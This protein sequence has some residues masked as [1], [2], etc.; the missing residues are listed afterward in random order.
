MTEE[1]WNVKTWNELTT[2]ELHNVLDLR[3][4]VF[5]V[6]QECPYPELDGKDKSAL[7][8]WS[9]DELGV[10][11]YLRILP[12]G[13]SYKE[14]SIGRVVVRKGV[15]KRGLGRLVMHKGMELCK[16]HFGSSIRI[17]AQAY[18]LEFYEALG[19]VRVSNTTYLED[20]IPHYEMIK[21]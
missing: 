9:E 7:H 5:V 16:H 18:L 10:S 20:G 6:E 15:R 8:L 13:L 14:S 17:S 2:E 21:K 11:S 1:S 19:F 3:I 4:R 12:P